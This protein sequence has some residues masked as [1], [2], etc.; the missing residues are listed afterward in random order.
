M[1]YGKLFE[2][3]VA[4]YSELLLGTQEL[5]K[6]YML[7]MRMPYESHPSLRDNSVVALKDRIAEESKIRFDLASESDSFSTE[8]EFITLSKNGKDSYDDNK[9]SPFE[10]KMSGFVRQ[11]SKDTIVV[12]IPER[13]HVKL[14]MLL[15]GS[16]TLLPVQVL[17]EVGNGSSLDLFEWFG[18]ASEYNRMVAP[19][20]VINAGKR[21][22][23]EVSILHNESPSTAVASVNVAKALDGSSLRLNSVYCGGGIT[24]S[25]TIADAVG[26][27]SSVLVNEIVLGNAE[28]R[29]DLSNFLLNSSKS[30]T[31]TLKSGAVLKDKSN[32][33]FKGYANVAKGASDSV[34]NIEERGLVVDA[35]AKMQSLPDM[36]IACRDVALASHSAAT[37]PVDPELLFYLNSRGI[38]SETA[39]RM[40]IASFLSKYLADVGNDI[41]KEVAVSILLDKLDRG[42]NSQVPAISTKSFWMVPKRVKE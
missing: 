6:K 5:Y 22:S 2:D 25:T 19:L 15:L 20:Q 1:E 39:R 36:S 21:S 34:S 42:T 24:K 12:K 29:F 28:Q 7:E 13:T 14:N 10:E 31:A 40:L 9:F 33:V 41:V 23:V 18:S 26:I 11:R 32:C 8:S 17:I 3:A 37:A 27:G 35:G 16:G 30:T 38:D 4:G